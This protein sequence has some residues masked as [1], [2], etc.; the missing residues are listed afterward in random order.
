MAP[1]KT[2]TSTGTSSILRLPVDS[3]H[4]SSVR[5]FDQL[6]YIPESGIWTPGKKST[7]IFDYTR[8][9]DRSAIN[10]FTNDYVGV[11]NDIRAQAKS[12]SQTAISMEQDASEELHN[13]AVIFKLSRL[14]WYNDSKFI[15]TKPGYSWSSSNHQQGETVDEHHHFQD[16]SVLAEYAAPLLAYGVANISF[17]ANSLHSSHPITM[18]PANATRRSQSFIKDSAVYAWDVNKK[19]FPGGGGVLSLYKG[20]GATKRIEIGRYQSD[21]GKFVPG[22]IL[23]IDSIEIDVVVAVLTLLSVLSQRESF[24]LPTGSWAG[25]IV[26]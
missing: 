11:N 14:H 4:D 5:H 8:Q 18:K 16:E 12:L 26:A 19:L 23:V 22:G 15:V 3:R 13:P 17:P 7:P 10:W 24:S 9:F 20:I 1:T 2:V 21:G 25:M 6:L